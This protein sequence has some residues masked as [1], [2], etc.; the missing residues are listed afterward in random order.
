MSN[1]L[2]DVLT[3]QP[4]LLGQLGRRLL[5]IGAEMV[6]GRLD[7]KIA[8]L[9][10]VHSDTEHPS[11]QSLDEAIVTI[12]REARHEQLS[13]ELDEAVRALLMALAS[14]LAVELVALLVN[15]AGVS[16]P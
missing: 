13:P 6:A 9:L 15:R 10:A 2:L 5:D 1:P 12:Q 14:G 11:W 4:E 3:R 8:A 7:D 16:T